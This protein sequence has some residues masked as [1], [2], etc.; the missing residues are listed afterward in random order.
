[1]GEPAGVLLLID[2][3]VVRL[4]RAEPVAPD[5]HRA[6]VVVELDVEEAAAVR[7]SR[8]RRRRSP[9]RG[10]QDRQTSPSRARGSRNIPSPWCRRS[11]PAACDP[12]NAARSPN[13]KYSSSAASCVAVEHDLHVAAVARHAAEHL[14]L[15]ALAEFAQIGERA[16]RRGHA[17]IVLL[18][19]PAHLRHQLLLQGGGMAEQALGVVVLGF[20]IFPDIRVEHRGIAQHLLPVWRPS[21]RRNRRSR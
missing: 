17:G 3:G 18:D 7:G 12:A 6:V 19:P 1:M 15:P 20:Q 13:L 2:Q 14:M 9:R 11:T 4:L 10:R 5:L 8:P 21:A 16:V